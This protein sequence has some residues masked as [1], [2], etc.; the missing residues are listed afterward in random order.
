VCY[1]CEKKDMQ[2]EVKDPALKKLLDIPEEFYKENSFL[3]AIKINCIR[4]GSLTQP[5]IEAFKKTLEDMKR[6]KEKE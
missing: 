4:Y 1:E 6:K 2:G 3:R 5:Q